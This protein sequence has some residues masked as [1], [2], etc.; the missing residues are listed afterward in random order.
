MF[1]TLFT[2]LSQYNK[3]VWGQTHVDAWLLNYT[4]N[5]KGG[6]GLTIYNLKREHKFI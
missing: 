3:Q 5:Q 2:T 1:S 4:T 6:D